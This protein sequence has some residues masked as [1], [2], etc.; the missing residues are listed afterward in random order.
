M[1]G[2][3]RTTPFSGPAPGLPKVPAGRPPDKNQQ[4][5]DFICVSG[6]PTGFETSAAC[7][8]YPRSPLRAIMR[9]PPESL[10]SYHDS[11]Y[12]IVLKI[13]AFWKRITPVPLCGMA[14]SIL[15]GCSPK[16]PTTPNTGSLTPLHVKFISV[17]NPVAEM[18]TD[19]TLTRT[20]WFNVPVARFSGTAITI[21]GR[22]TTAQELQDWAKKY[23]ERKI[24]RALWVQI[25]PGSSRNAEQALLPIVG[26]FPDLHVFQVD[27]GFS[28]PKL[29]R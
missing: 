15:V 24:E 7:S 9:D 21:F 1:A 12:L 13:K 26:M 4:D 8:K 19:D 27:Y 25:A 10:H 23:Y 22:G 2:Q 16:S 29:H 5:R 14:L 28:C 17:D 3:H 20:E 11:E 18:C 6:C